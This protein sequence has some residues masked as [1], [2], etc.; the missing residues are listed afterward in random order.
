MTRGMFASVGDMEDS[1]Q[2]IGGNCRVVDKSEGSKSGIHETPDEI[3]CVLAELYG[4]EGL[5]AQSRKERGK[6]EQLGV[7]VGK[8]QGSL[9]RGR[10]AGKVL[11]VLDAVEREMYGE[12]RR[13]VSEVEL[14]SE[15]VWEL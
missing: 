4:K 8:L 15:P 12:V 9:A 2:P 14:T 6:L 10:D 1:D 13:G 3:A 11:R 7:I 5:I